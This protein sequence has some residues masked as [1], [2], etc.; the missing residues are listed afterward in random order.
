MKFSRLFSTIDTHTCGQPTRTITSGIPPIP[1]ST[2]VDKMLY[3]KKHMDWIRT[4]LMFEP[5]GHSIMSGVIL[6]EP[7][8]PGVDY[9]VIFIETGGYLPMC[10]HDT[11]GVCT[12]LVETGMVNVQEPE[13]KI[14]LETPAGLTKVVV[15]VEN[16]KALSVTFRNIPLFVSCRMPGSKFPATEK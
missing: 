16:G 4:A 11:I 12:A 15:R 9:G 2:V 5:R 1:G 10:G 13:T 8:V 7:S 6:V 14:T 3:L